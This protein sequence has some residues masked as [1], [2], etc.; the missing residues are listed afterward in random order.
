MLSKDGEL[1][2]ATLDLAHIN[3]DKTRSYMHF[4]AA[5][6]RNRKGIVLV[7]VAG[8]AITITVDF[9]DDGTQ[10]H[11]YVSLE[12]SF[13]AIVYLKPGMTIGQVGGSA[14]AIPYWLDPGASIQN[15]FLASYVLRASIDSA[16]A[17]KLK[18]SDSFDMPDDGYRGGTSSEDSTDTLSGFGN[19]YD[20]DDL[21]DESDS[22]TVNPGYSR[23]NRFV[24]WW[25][26]KTLGFRSRLVTIIV[27]FG[28]TVLTFFASMGSNIKKGFTPVVKATKKRA[29]K[30]KQWFMKQAAIKYAL[31]LAEDLGEAMASVGNLAT[32]GNL[33]KSAKE[34]SLINK[35]LGRYD[36][37]R[38]AVQD[39][40]ERV[41]GELKSKPKRT[42]AGAVIFFVVFAGITIRTVTK[43]KDIFAQ[44]KKTF[45]SPLV[46]LAVRKFPKHLRKEK[47]ESAMDVA[48]DG[49]MWMLFLGSLKSPAKAWNIFVEMS[50]T[51]YFLN[52]LK[53]DMA[54]S[55]KIVFCFIATVV[56]HVIRRHLRKKNVPLKHGPVGGFGRSD[57][58]SFTKEELL[59]DP[60]F[61]NA[62]RNQS[63][64]A[65][66]V[67]PTGFN[68]QAESADNSEPHSELKCKCPTGMTCAACSLERGQSS[69]ETS[70]DQREARGKMKKG[71]RGAR[72][73]SV[74]TVGSVYGALR[75]F[76]FKN[77]D[78]DYR[79]EM[80][81]DNFQ[82]FMDRVQQSGAYDDLLEME[83]Q[84]EDVDWER[85]HDFDDYDEWDY[86]DWENDYDKYYEETYAPRIIEVLDRRAYKEGKLPGDLKSFISME[87]ISSKAWDPFLQLK[88]R[89]KKGRQYLRDRVHK[90]GV[91]KLESREGS[92]SNDK[93][94]DARGYY[95]SVFCLFL[96]NKGEKKFLHFV[97]RV[98]GMYCTTKHS[99]ANVDPSSLEVFPLSSCEITKSKRDNINSIVVMDA[100][101]Y[102]KVKTV[103]TGEHDLA[104]LRL[105]SEGKLYHQGVIPKTQRMQKGLTSLTGLPIAVVD[106]N[107]ALHIGSSTDIRSRPTE[108]RYTANSGGSSG[109]CGL[110]IINLK[111]GQ[112]LGI[113]CAYDNVFNVN[114]GI[115]LA[116]DEFMS[117]YQPLNSPAPVHH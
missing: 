48:N 51:Y 8:N 107:M 86:K 96:V 116:A 74:K 84:D 80:Y 72:N 43:R 100:D 115:R 82:E 40:W 30:V 92:V 56:R 28:Y 77:Y 64:A 4:R 25:N 75:K 45:V 31:E 109:T 23:W 55:E 66:M 26:H 32:L 103:Q 87:K 3:W 44:I 42:T 18:R 73:A 79:D 101:R 90:A 29:R 93:E 5:E 99:I 20:D 2:K 59:N 110:P 106:W 27:M 21:N 98:N 17:E 46:R 69:Q 62:V 15:P 71:G 108:F 58:P 47:R 76:Y 36:M 89:F 68:Q 57:G 60:D 105:E 41:S 112:I 33:S 12:T 67:G 85:E 6:N 61:I 78:K 97:T 70:Q 52:K 53:P 11:H 117:L 102:S 91:F 49:A 83:Y 113:H 95:N 88:N 34:K 13:P 10:A 39:L 114:V 14:G 7:D 24:S 81:G 50:V 35:L 37:C 104:L 1:V 94:I 63:F 9:N 111:T 22:E 65:A 19:L 38:D 16:Q 54:T